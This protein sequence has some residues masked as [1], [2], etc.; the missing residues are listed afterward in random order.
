MNYR[1]DIYYIQLMIN[2]ALL[3][4]CFE[5]ESLRYDKAKLVTCG[6]KKTFN[7]FQSKSLHQQM[8]I[9]SAHEY[10]KVENLSQ[11][12]EADKLFAIE[13]CRATLSKTFVGEYFGRKIRL[14]WTRKECPIFGYDSH[15]LL[16]PESFSLGHSALEI[17]EHLNN[18][19]IE[20]KIDYSMM[21]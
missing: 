7:T 21:R 12:D 14:P 3:N 11:L 18:R 10:R 8:L 13:Y 19:N 5:D 4:V 9:G 17:R 20:T 2:K 1:H 15:V 16:Q 6:M